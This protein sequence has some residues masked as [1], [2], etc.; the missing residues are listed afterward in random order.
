MSP[1]AVIRTR[2]DSC[3]AC[4]TPCPLQRDTAA[5]ADPCAACPLPRP[6]WPQW[7]CKQGAG[8]V[9]A[10]QI[11]RRVLSPIEQAAPAARGF[12]QQI[13]KCGGC[14]QARQRMGSSEPHRDPGIVV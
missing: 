14:H 5:H 6:R 12:I 9:L 10:D 3:A 7:D 13:R 8:D 1:R 4:P 11:D 2:A